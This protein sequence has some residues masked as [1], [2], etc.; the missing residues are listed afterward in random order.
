M[1][2][3][4]RPAAPPTAPNPYASALDGLVL[5]DPVDAFFGFC[6]EREAV[7]E[8]RA[9]GRAPPWSDDP[10]FQR[11]RFLNVF[12]EDDR[13]TKAIFRFVA[14][15]AVPVHARGGGGGGGGSGGGGSGGGGD[16]GDEG[17][18]GSL[19][20]LIHALF[21]ARW[22]NSQATL[23]GL[24]VSMLQ[25]Q[26]G[27]GQGDEGDVGGGGEG[28]GGDEGGVLLRA[29]LAAMASP[30]WC[31]VTAYP[32]EPISWAGAEGGGDGDGGVGG[33]EGGGGGGGGGGGEGAAPPRH[34]Y[35][36][37]DAAACLFG[38]GAMRRWLTA[39]VLAA[40]GSVVDATRAIA[41]AFGMSNDFP[42][43]M[44]VMDIA[45][46]RPDVIDPAS[47]VPTGIGAVAFLDRLQ[48]HL[49]LATHDA[50]IGAVIAAQP[51]RWP[52]ARRALQPIDV[53]YLS[54]ESRK[55]YSYVN[56]TKAFE[57]KNVFVPG[58]TPS[59]EF[60]VKEEEAAAAAAAAVAG[61]GAAA[62]GAGGAVAAVPPRVC[63]IAGGPCSGKSTL[64]AALRADTGGG[65]R[66]VAEVA[67]ELIR[68]GVA[69]GRSAEETRLDPV[70]W[71]MELL[72]RDYELFDGLLRGEEEEEEEGE[73]AAAAA[74]A[75]AAEGAGAV[76]FADT[77]FVE[78]LAYARRA[79]IEVGPGV[80]A[81][82]ARLRYARVFFLAPLEEYESTAVRLESQR[83]AA[84]LSAEIRACYEGELG[85]ELCVVPAAPTAERVRIVRESVASMLS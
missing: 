59:L 8:R 35:S 79:G 43:F 58:L 9:S 31:N 36:R 38:S 25:Q 74:A 20:A 68:A 15:I 27:Q 28:G 49:G 30:P 72:R 41:R 21:F 57:G 60:D 40:R 33:G 13:T 82:L 18:G 14:P 80:R 77:S 67:E 84:E 45:W 85:Y 66:V 61:A 23:D 34:R 24:H 70:A 39:T 3:T 6:R 26:Q 12:R 22:C 32:V 7:R 81:W 2:N 69:A 63:V 83:L 16:G 76:V 54:C 52:G 46:F 50:A 62:A 78:D 37:L 56:G 55:Y 4:E 47:H 75:A 71:Q 17:G 10:I 73:G 51:A 48:A 65:F 53:E 64:C 11:G 42:V 1:A 5:D 19:E 44:A 29:R